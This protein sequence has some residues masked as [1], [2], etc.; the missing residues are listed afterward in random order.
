M[1]LSKRSQLEDGGCEGNHCYSDQQSD[2]DSYNTLHDV[3]WGGFV[4]GGV[5]AAAG[6][7]LW[8]TAPKPDQSRVSL[9]LVGNGLR[10]KGTF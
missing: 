5:S 2:V 10:V 8:V 6:A 1:A 9:D 4:L 7:V 3:A